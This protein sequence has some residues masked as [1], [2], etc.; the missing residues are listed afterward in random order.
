[1]KTEK[2]FNTKT[3]DRMK[4][5]DYGNN[6]LN[7]IAYDPASGDYFL[8]GKRWSLMFRVQITPKE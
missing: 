3:N 8:T 4:T 7:G 2:K 6:V 1:L 5:W